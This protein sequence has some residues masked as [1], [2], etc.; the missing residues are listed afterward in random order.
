MW[1]VFAGASVC[2]VGSEDVLVSLWIILIIIVERNY[3]K[4]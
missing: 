1:S 4:L 3:H 2:P